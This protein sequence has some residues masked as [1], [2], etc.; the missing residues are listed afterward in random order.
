[1][2]GPVRKDVPTHPEH[3]KFEVRVEVDGDRPAQFAFDKLEE[4]GWPKMK[5]VS[6]PSKACITRVPNHW[7]YT[8]NIVQLT[9]P[10]IE[11]EDEKSEDEKWHP[12]QTGE[13]EFTKN[14]RRSVL[15]TIK[16]IA[17]SAMPQHLHIVVD[18]KLAHLAVGLS[19]AG[20]VM[21]AVFKDPSIN[22]SICSASQIRAFTGYNKMHCLLWIKSTKSKSSDAA[23]RSDS[24]PPVEEAHAGAHMDTDHSGLNTSLIVPQKLLIDVTVLC[25]D[26]NAEIAASKLCESGNSRVCVAIRPA[27]APNPARE[28]NP[29]TI[30]SALSITQRLFQCLLL[31]Q[32]LPPQQ[33]HEHFSQEGQEGFDDLEHHKLQLTA[34]MISRCPGDVDQDAAPLALDDFKPAETTTLIKDKVIADGKFCRLLFTSPHYATTVAENHKLGV[35]DM[36]TAITTSP[37]ELKLF[38]FIVDPEEKNVAAC[39]TGVVQAVCAHAMCHKTVE[40]VTFWDVSRDG[41]LQIEDL[42]E[43]RACGRGTVVQLRSTAMTR[44]MVSANELEIAARALNKSAY[45]IHN[46]NI[47][48]IGAMESKEWERFTN[49][50][51]QFEGQS[52]AVHL[53]PSIGLQE[54]KEVD[55]MQSVEF[56]PVF[57]SSEALMTHLPPKPNHEQSSSAIQFNPPSSAT[58][59]TDKYTVR[60]EGDGAEEVPPQ[61]AV[62]GLSEKIMDDRS[63][64]IASEAAWKGCLEVL[65][66]ASESVIE[67]LERLASES[68][69]FKTRSGSHILKITAAAPVF[70]C[71]ATEESASDL[72]RLHENIARKCQESGI[73]PTAESTNAV[74]SRTPDGGRIIV[75]ASTIGAILDRGV[76]DPENF[77]ILVGEEGMQSEYTPA[78]DRDGDPVYRSESV[79]GSRTL[80][81][82][83]ESWYHSGFMG[84]FYKMYK[85]DDLD[86]NPRRPPKQGKWVR[87]DDAGAPPAEVEFP[88]RHVIKVAGEVGS[89]SVGISLGD[90]GGIKH[91]GDDLNPRSRERSALRTEADRMRA[92]APDCAVNGSL[93]RFRTKVS[94]MNWSIMSWFKGKPKHAKF[95]TDDKGQKELAKHFWKKEHA[96]LFTAPTSE[97]HLLSIVRKRPGG[98]A[99]HLGFFDGTLLDVIPDIEENQEVRERLSANFHTE[100]EPEPEA[101]FFSSGVTYFTSFFTQTAPKTTA[102]RSPPKKI[103]LG[104]ATMQLLQGKSM[105][106]QLSAGILGSLGLG[107]CWGSH[108]TATFEGAYSTPLAYTYSDLLA[109]LRSVGEFDIS[110]YQGEEFLTFVT[111]LYYADKYHFDFGGNADAEVKG[112]VSGAAAG[113]PV[114]IGANAAAYHAKNRTADYDNT[115][116]ANA[117]I[118]F[119]AR[120]LRVKVVPNKD[121]RNMA[122]FKIDT[123]TSAGANVKFLDVAAITANDIAELVGKD[124]EL[125][126][127]AAFGHT[128]DVEN[129]T[130][131]P[132]LDNALDDDIC[133][134]LEPEDQVYRLDVENE[135]SFIESC[136][137]L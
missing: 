135:A 20:T 92:G 121:N 50:N 88:I 21:H 95:K 7:I 55:D 79:W 107:T 43:I 125:M 129:V 127:N 85:T 29:A 70:S 99:H 137:I 72:R 69:S 2:A 112:N 12:P 13:W 102:S 111:R 86:V 34:T 24:S 113:V 1:M 123:V 136:A 27:S 37:Q 65:V 35:L 23:R 63:A 19:A 39:A 54:Y 22:Y 41:H 119:A 61:E 17:R 60:L 52:K 77:A 84:D 110:K 32:P 87:C 26:D 83:G 68:T 57:V 96:V 124:G 31:P 9:S 105:G 132:A 36:A 14:D 49:H 8:G 115:D 10:K 64:P 51:R 97:P 62:D 46:N 48:I 120:M 100:P 89:Q 47:V 33:I 42:E 118:A 6:G 45:F 40:V 130:L 38:I 82:E 91:S 81:R 74:L 58:R 90:V 76:P 75:P 66:S 5:R 108:V 131:L 94:M 80:F 44:A 78:G 30:R 53:E 56:L 73:R 3:W 4:N 104:D 126:S 103:R 133:S 93:R 15:V 18:C 16:P 11:S 67:D 116:P 128:E 106:A 28:C 98:K 134:Q 59:T 25:H 71:P 122:K 114:G 109:D 101:S 117:P